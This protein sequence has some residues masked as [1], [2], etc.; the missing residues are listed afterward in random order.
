METINKKVW[1]ATPTYH[2]EE[3]DYIIEAIE[4]NWKSTI[5]EN[6]DE[7]ERL[8]CEKTGCKYAVAVI[9]GQHNAPQRVFP[10]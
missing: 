3:I 2:K 8:M 5:G 7:V 9:N 10:P 1:L 6:I 4:T